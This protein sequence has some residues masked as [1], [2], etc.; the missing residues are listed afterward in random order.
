MRKT[1]LIGLILAV[2][3]PLA[4]PASAQDTI[5]HVVQ[6][7]ENLFRIAL[8][9]GTT[10]QTVAAANGIVNVNQI[11]RKCNEED[12]VTVEE[13]RQ[14]RRELEK[15]YLFWFNCFLWFW[16]GSFFGFGRGAC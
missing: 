3:L 2:V 9:Y 8:R 1:L 10:Y 7:G 5:V 12:L 11:A 6:R 14:V 16:S 13:L 4:T 15:C